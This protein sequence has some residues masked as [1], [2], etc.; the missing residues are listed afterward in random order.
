MDSLRFKEAGAQQKL[1]K[2]LLLLATESNITNRAEVEVI[3]ANYKIA[4]AKLKRLQAIHAIRRHE[5]KLNE[6]DPAP[7]MNEPDFGNSTEIMVAV[8][9]AEN[10]VAAQKKY[11]D[12]YVESVTLRFEAQM[13]AA[14]LALKKSQAL[15]T[16]AA[17]NSPGMTGA[18]SVIMEGAATG[19]GSSESATGI[20]L[21]QSST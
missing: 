2:A 4:E 18:S 19:S 20:A 1:H 8:H 13:H 16:V 5:L 11:R 10:E 15:L 3:E 21:D 12:A 6:D 9:S 7:T 14:A 17:V